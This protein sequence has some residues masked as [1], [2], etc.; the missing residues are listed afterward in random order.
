MF[1]PYS[2]VVERVVRRLYD[3]LGERERR[4]YAAAEALKLGRGS[5]VYLTRLL[6]CDA[7]TIRRGQRELDQP[8]PLPPGRSR[9][10]GA[11][12]HRS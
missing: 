11:A 4:L 3:T 10:K 9:K 12:E 2:P 6:D 8:S 5:L 7:K 1:T